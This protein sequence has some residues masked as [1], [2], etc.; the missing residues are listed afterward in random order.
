[1]KK[2]WKQIIVVGALAALL[3]GLALANG[4]GTVDGLRKDIHAVTANPAERI[5]Q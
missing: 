1:M 4:C 2:Y 3:V 5:N